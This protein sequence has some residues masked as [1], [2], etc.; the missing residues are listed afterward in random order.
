MRHIIL[1]SHHRYADGLRDTLE[2]IGGVKDVNVLCAYVDE[3]PLEDQVKSVF[4]SFASEDEVL[5]F[6][7][8]MQGSVSQAFVPYMNDH[9]FLIAGANVI[10]CLEMIV[11][12]SPLST[13]KIEG[14]LEQARL[15]MRLMNTY[16][17]EES[18]EDE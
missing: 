6:T 3:T 15:S 7:D 11:S 10:C 14:I 1:A 17:V 5:I 8:I 9:V 4:S 16:Q 2:F 13:D 12:P 18:D